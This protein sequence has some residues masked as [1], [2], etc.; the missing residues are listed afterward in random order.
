MSAALDT[1]FGIGALETAAEAGLSWRYRLPLPAQ[2]RQLLVLC[3]GVGADEMS[4][5]AV[6][7][8]VDADT[9][10]VLARGPLTLAPGHYGWFRVAFTAQGPQIDAAQAD[11]ARRTLI[12]FVEYLQ[13]RH[14]R[15]PAQTVVAGFSQGGIISASVALTAPQIVAGFAVL[16]GRILPELRAQLAAPAALAQLQGYIA[17][18]EVDDKLPIF[19]AERARQWLTELGVPH[20]AHRYPI[21]HGIDAAVRDDFVAWLRRSAALSA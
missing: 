13:Q 1:G 12:G 14:D 2:P 9:L 5:A 17:H 4:L 18:G 20:E 3:H 16:S 21:G 11:A 19:W 8:A 15:R 10:V 7:A 6:A